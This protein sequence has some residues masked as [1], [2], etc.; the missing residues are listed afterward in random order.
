[1]DGDGVGDL[2][3]SG[4]AFNAAPGFAY[5]VSG[6]ALRGQDGVVDLQD[7]VDQGGAWRM[8]GGANASDGPGWWVSTWPALA[9]V[10]WRR[11]GRVRRDVVGLLSDANRFDA[12]LMMWV[13]KDDLESLF[14]SDGTLE[15]P[16]RL[17]SALLD[18]DFE[19]ISGGFIGGSSLQTG[20]HPNRLGT[21]R[22]ASCRRAA[23][24]MAT[25]GPIS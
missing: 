13:S 18:G 14:G 1:M 12:S 10:E 23:I 8:T 25:G 2:L 9:M 7:L 5:L 3:V 21:A 11:R 16:E 24:S 20:S 15:V 4:A 22:R 19:D 17:S 6:A